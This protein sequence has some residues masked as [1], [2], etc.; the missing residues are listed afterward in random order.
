MSVLK[1]SVHKTIN[2]DI[3]TSGFFNSNNDCPLPNDF[4]IKY[5]KI[6]IYSFIVK[7][8]CLIKHCDYILLLEQMTDLLEYLDFC[9]QFFERGEGRGVGMCFLLI[10]H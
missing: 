4:T 8:H 9:M 5:V 6:L 10:H 3:W 7:L 1:K 2:N